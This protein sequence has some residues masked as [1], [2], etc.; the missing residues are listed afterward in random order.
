MSGRRQGKTLFPYK[1]CDG[2]ETAM[3]RKHFHYPFILICLDSNFLARE[4]PAG[5]SALQ[6][7][8]CVLSGRQSWVP[9]TWSHS[10]FPVALLRPHHRPDRRFCQFRIGW[11]IRGWDR[12]ERILQKY[13]VPFW[14]TASGN[15]SMAYPISRNTAASFS[16][17]TASMSIQKSTSA[18]CLWYP[19][20]LTAPPPT[21]S[22]LMPCLLARWMKVSMFSFHWFSIGFDYNLEV[23]VDTCFVALLDGKLG[24]PLAERQKCIKPLRRWKPKEGFL[25][26]TVAFILVAVVYFHAKGKVREYFWAISR[27]F[28]AMCS[29]FLRIAKQWWHRYGW[30]NLL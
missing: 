25:L 28:R 10:P 21:I 4:C 27:L 16:R 11:S 12:Q 17:F 14:P 15:D 5:L 1:W 22:I 6:P 3:L 26:K 13:F 29:V 23:I 20:K 2:W 9:A 18:E 30:C 8:V 24:H 19:W 7:F